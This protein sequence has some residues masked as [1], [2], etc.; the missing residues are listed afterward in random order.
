MQTYPLRRSRFQRHR[1]GEGDC[2]CT[3]CGE[4]TRYLEFQRHRPGEGD[5]K[6][7]ICTIALLRDLGFSAIA[8]GKGTAS[9]ILQNTKRSL[10]TVSAPSPRG[11]G[12]Q[13]RNRW[14]SSRRLYRFS[15]IAPGKGTARY[16]P[17]P[18]S[19]P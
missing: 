1:P 10:Q 14:W 18:W 12:L 11:R 2:K 4:E 5:C 16:P 19:A 17:A 3:V 9:R 6:T 15:A 13:G 8:P 7:A